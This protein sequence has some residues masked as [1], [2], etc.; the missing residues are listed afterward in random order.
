MMR[1]TWKRALSA[2]L[3]VCM[4]ATLLVVPAAAADSTYVWVDGTT[5]TFFTVDTSSMRT[6]SEITVDGNKYTRG[7]KLG[8]D[9]ITFTVPEGQSGSVKVLVG[10]RATSVAQADI[11][12]D[13]TK[14]SVGTY[15]ETTP[16]T[17]TK[18]L[19]QGA[20]TI[21]KG[22]KDATVYR[23][24]WVPASTTSEF[25][26]GV[27]I[28][29]DQDNENLNADVRSQDVTLSLKATVTGG[30]SGTVAADSWK[31]FKGE[32]EVVDGT[33]TVTGN[34][35]GKTA[36]VNVAANAVR[37]QYTIKATSTDNAQG[38]E[39]GESTKFTG[40]ATLRVRRAVVDT[41]TLT[42]PA[43]STVNMK[44][45]DEPVAVEIATTWVTADGDCII[46]PA[47]DADQV[48]FASNDETVVTVSTGDV[49]NDGK[50]TLT[51][52]G[53]GSTT[54]TATSTRN[55]TDGQPKVVTLNVTV[56]KGETTL[57]LS[58]PRNTQ[59]VAA[60][61]Y[62][63]FELTGLPSNAAKQPYEYVTVTPDTGVTVSAPAEGDKPYDEGST[64][65][66]GWNV[67]VA[68]P[69]NSSNT[70]DVEYTVA[71]SYGA[72]SND[73][74]DVADAD[75]RTVKVLSTA[76]KNI[77]VT[78]Q[79]GSGATVAKTS[80]DTLTL[81]ADAVLN[82]STGTPAADQTGLTFTWKK[83]NQ[84]L[85]AG[86]N[87]SISSA[88][89]TIEGH[90][91]H[92]ESTLTITGILVADAGTY[93]CEVSHADVDAPA[94]A[95]FTV[96]VAKK[97]G[98]VPRADVDASTRVLSNVQAGW[99][100]SLNGN[101]SDAKWVDIDAASV[102]IPA[103]IEGVDM[104]AVQG[105]YVQDPGDDETLPAFQ[106]IE[107]TR[108]TTP[109]LEA[110]DGALKITNY[111]EAYKDLY[112]YKTA[113][114]AD[115]TD[116]TVTEA[117]D[118]AS[119]TISGLTNGTEYQVRVKYGKYILQTLVPATGTPAEPAGDPTEL[120]E[121]IQTAKNKVIG[122]WYAD[123]AADVLAGAK[124]V[125]VSDGT[126]YNNAIKAAEA[127]ANAVDGTGAPS[128]TTT[129]L[130]NAKT[131]LQGAMDIFD[132]LEKKD[133]TKKQDAFILNMNEVSAQEIENQP[134]GT[135]ANTVAN[136]GTQGF[137]TLLG[138]KDT[139]AKAAVQ[140][141]DM[142]FD[143]G[144]YGTHRWNAQGKVEL[145]SSQYY[146]GIKFTTTVANSTVK[147]WAANVGGS[148]RSLQAIGA[149]AVT[150]AEYAANEFKMAELTLAT[151]GTYYLGGTNTLQIYRVEVVQPGVDPVPTAYDITV[152][153]AENG[154]VKTTVGGVDAD[155]ACEGDEV[156]IVA[157]PANTGFTVD[158]VKVTKADN[159]E[160]TVTENKFTMPA[161]A[162]TVTVTFKST[163]VTPT[164]SAI[165]KAAATNG[166]FTV[167]VGDAEVTEAAEG[168]TVVVTPT[169][170]N[171]Y[172]VDAV[173]TTPA[174]T[175]TKQDDGTY[176]F[177]MPGEAVTVTVTFKEVQVTPTEYNITVTAGANGTATASAA[178]AAAGTEITLTI[179][180][181]QGYEVD[182]ITSADVTVAN[183]KFTMPA[184]DVTI[185][186]TF[187]QTQTPTP[188]GVHTF[189][190]KTLTQAAA[191]S[192]ASGAYAEDNY[193]TLVPST[194]TKYDQSNKEWK[195]D[196]FGDNAYDPSGD[197]AVS[198]VVR[199]N[200][201]GATKADGPAIKFTTAKD[202]A[203]VQI[204]WVQG[205]GDT[206]DKDASG[207]KL[208][209]FTDVGIRQIALMK[210]DAT[211]V[212]ASTLAHT[213]TTP[214]GEGRIKANDP[215]YTELTVATA[216]TYMIGS[217]EGSNYIFKIVVTEDAGTTPT[218]TEHN[219]TVTAGEH[220][221]A[222]ASAAKA[223]KD[224]EITLTITPE[225]GYEVDQITSADVTVANNKFTMPDKD[226]AISVTF[227][228]TTVTPPQVDKTALDAAITAAEAVDVAGVK[229]SEDGA[230]VPTT[231][232]WIAKDVKDAFDKALTDA[233]AVADTAT[234]AEVDAAAK[235]L[236]DATKALT[237]AI[238]NA[239]YG[240]KA[241]D[242]TDLTAAIEAAKAKMEGVLTSA[243]GSD[244]D[245]DKTWVTAAVKT[246]L[247]NAIQA[248]QD[249]VDN[250]EATDEDIAKAVTDLNTASDAFKPAAG[251]KTSGGYRPGSSSG[252]GSN[253]NTTDKKTETL[254]DGT[255]RVTETAKDGT[256]TVTDTKPDGTKTVTTTTP[257]GETTIDVT[258]G[259]G[260]ESVQVAVPVDNASSGLVAVIVKPDG[261]EE[262]IRD[263][264]VVDDEV[265]FDLDENAKVKVV[266]N[267]KSFVDVPGHWA[268][269]DV[270]FVTARDLFNGVSDTHFAPNAT[271][272]RSMMATVLYRL[273]GETKADKSVDFSDVTT[274][275][276]FA[277]AV[278][279]ASEAGV[280]NGYTDGSFGPNRSITREELVVMIYRY[281]G[282]PEVDAAMGMAGFNDVDQISTWAEA[283]MRWAVQNG[284]IQG[285]G[286]GTLD[287]Q[288]NAS[289]AEVSAV[290]QRYVKL[291]K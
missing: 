161:E 112:Q 201:G 219:I 29:D 45:G 138:N 262:I 199:F 189:E 73:L 250:A 11:S 285:K 89:C 162:V 92:T 38:T 72:E 133:G 18:E 275:D 148:A 205:G 184:K 290:L 109:V 80:G 167:K 130:N 214:G 135:A 142:L 43:S 263:S 191:G 269:S 62:L 116:A 3:T 51:A 228:A 113:S 223:V 104:T 226:V 12:I 60:G 108:A 48:T 53:V 158:T 177:P 164:T 281:A 55:D 212:E 49:D 74:W 84:E 76:K 277:A 203:K 242:K 78:G 235:A 98:T 278:D 231:E 247:E 249:V 111:Q 79:T 96:T 271:M 21:G 37:G 25:V 253:A 27:K 234:Q 237:D 149:A 216:G 102:T 57:T 258:L 23:V 238:E 101:G 86:S 230:D 44:M 147:V 120:K 95:D 99:K 241:A 193:F 264:V 188:S 152:A 36:V 90:T 232:K 118:K 41:M 211:V 165:T 20:H 59:V 137:F 276:W 173:A 24:E 284:I 46:Q 105:I 160:V 198:K 287:P 174:A 121:L 71:A 266:N 40:S 272:T 282:S 30:T 122:I 209:T 204:W 195:A 260:A 39:G 139:G 255:K 5:N 22:T 70:D 35:D 4:I 185:N 64:A 240:T 156:T 127:V 32:D 85:T 289:R 153:A 65:V 50:A 187:K 58:Q 14:V 134:K 16:A 236:T 136:L 208:G 144:F 10:S 8:V 224:T 257:A 210:T 131:A 97:E 146:K 61:G 163:G 218:P 145:S 267:T 88:P 9:T 13:G 107:L 28:T 155:S 56:G 248:A 254:T 252:S 6:V 93:T 274:G 243:N 192:A 200:M 47:S 126:T 2:I 172:E 179:T 183:N 154:T 259:H 217:A 115:W 286:N 159:S 182:Q 103:T 100:Y 125:P 246:A 82:E 31:V 197:N 176:T 207:N 15:G 157:T 261:T 26:T 110:L 140:N 186:V 114:D 117:E 288:G 169:A 194:K 280:I 94:T 77:K 124:F 34:D 220:G 251:T 273:D 229:V 68:L 83:G 215:E 119:A 52:V 256:V 227:K 168:A 221:T 132:A 233:K 141:S 196:T 175:V 268:E 128:S 69:A 17:V 244:V 181:E 42:A 143:D 123:N 54:V 33:V 81:S 171:G 213:G 239:A 166:S 291:A 19:T 225:Q 180:P 91:G 279:W 206:E 7:V 1:S 190:S 150:G 270:N 66:G 63:L 170:A 245:T 129:E 265:I 283:A 178:K 222:T 106:H 75:S 151:A 67:K 87:I 202:N